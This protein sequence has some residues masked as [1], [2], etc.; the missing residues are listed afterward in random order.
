MSETVYE[1]FSQWL[2][3]EVW[4][5]GWGTAR[6]AT[7]VSRHLRVARQTAHA[8]LGGGAIPKPAYCIAIGKAFGIDPD[9]VLTQAGHREP[10]PE[11][12][13]PPPDDSPAISLDIESYRK[14]S[15]EQQAEVNTFIQWLRERERKKEESG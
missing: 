5:R 2:Q 12:P 1:S 9:V 11:I 4:D 8:W 7:E 3:K 14:L 6:F 13:A 10:Q 15:V